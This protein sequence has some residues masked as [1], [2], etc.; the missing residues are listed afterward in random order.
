M[1]ILSRGIVRGDA[2]LNAIEV[3]GPKRIAAVILRDDDVELQTT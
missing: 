1:F 2:L 3:D